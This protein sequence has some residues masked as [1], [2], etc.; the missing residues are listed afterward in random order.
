MY[1]KKLL[2]AVVGA[3]I[4]LF[5]AS[6]AFAGWVSDGTIWYYQE[7]GANKTGWVQDNG[8]W[9][10]MNA[11]GK[12][13][14]G[15]IQD[16]Y[17]TYYLD[18]ASGA[19]LTGWQQI[20]GKWYFFSPEN[21]G[22]MLRKTT[23]PDGY[24]VNA[25]GVWVPDQ[26][27]KNSSTKS[28]STSSTYSVKK[29]KTK[30][31]SADDEDVNNNKSV[32]LDD[33]ALSEYAD[34]VIDLINEVREDHGVAP[35]SDNSILMDIAQERAE[36]IVENYSH[37]NSDGSKAYVEMMKDYGYNYSECAENITKGNTSPEAAVKAWVGSAGHKKN[38]LNK[39]FKETG[40]GVVEV[41]GKLYWVQVFGTR[42]HSKKSAS[43]DSDDNSVELSYGIDYD[44]LDSDYAFY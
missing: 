18:L 43:A 38:L 23:T 35:L 44:S 17:N 13:A 28:S 40:V 7:N 8:S 5:S 25:T 22:A 24:F 2:T 42:S 10:Y 12:M 16:G 26:E 39:T 27:I 3:M 6:S 4:S 32:S 29:Q 31:T 21:G 37:Y 9:Y 14:T 11:D 33:D 41:K 20:D 15:F 34:E 1:K 30:T 36:E 19:M